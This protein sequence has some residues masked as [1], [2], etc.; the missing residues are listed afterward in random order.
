MAKRLHESLR[1]PAEVDEGVAGAFGL[2]QE[3]QRGF[4]GRARSGPT[5]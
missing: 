5:V 3:I 1:S 2:R 4:F